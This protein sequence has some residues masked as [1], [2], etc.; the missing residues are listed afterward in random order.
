MVW[1]KKT[2]DTAV[3]EENAEAAAGEDRDK[4]ITEADKQELLE[5]FD[6]ESKTRTFVSP[7]V[8]MAYKIFAIL[9]TLYHLVFASG[10]WM[11]ETLKHRSLHVSM[12]LILAFAMYPATKKASRKIIAWYDYI[13]IALSAAVP[14][15]MWLD[16]F[17]IIN[18]AGK[19]NSM[20][21]IIGTLLT[22]L[23]LEATRRVCGMA[24]PIL[25]VIFI[26]YS[27]MGTKQGLI[28]VNIPGIFLHRG[29]TWQKL[30]SHFFA[31]TEG[32]YGSSVNVASTYIFL[33]IAFGEIMNKCGMGKFFNDIANA[34][35]G[36]SKGGPA[37]VAVVA[38]GL[39]GMING[40]AVAVV[41][42]T[43][44]FTI[45]LMK[46]T[47]Y[48]NEFSGAIVATGS[49][50]GQLMP[51]VMGA[52]A[53][54]MAETLG[55]KYSTLLVSAIIPAVIYYM[56]ILLQ[57]QMRAEKMGMQGT[58]KDQLPKVGEVMKEYG[59]LAIPLVFLI[60]M[61]FFSGKTVIM[62]AFYTILFTIVV[63]QLRPNTRMSLNDIID[64]M[65][66]SA[67]STVSVAIACACVGIIVGVCSIT[68]FAL[69]MASTIIQIGGQSLMFT[70][71]FTMVTCMIL[72]MGLPSIPSY[73]I[74]STIAAPALVTLGI[75]P[76][77]AHMFCFYFAM[78]ANLTPPVALAAFA[79]AGIAGGSPM[80]TGWAS[81]KL[82]LAG[83]I[84]P[85]MFVYNTELLLLDTP[86]AKGIQV[87][88][89]AAIGVFLISVAVE[90]F[91]FRKVNAV[92]RILC[93]A[94]AYLLID[95]GLITDIIGIAIC[96]GIVLLQKTMA[97]K[98][99]TIV[100]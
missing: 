12:I 9:V 7:A 58:P 79:A 70:L 84:L 65:V 94:G 93:F 45:P 1:K 31:N 74:T 38:S 35:A 3:P 25:G 69:N 13:L 98:H 91:L 28:P 37:K 62:A 44:S 18:R 100:T 61:L 34:L 33:F 36:G 56:G 54:I 27:L 95:S 15:Y 24:L 14:L 30:M 92:L 89:T 42:T 19:P 63:A 82:A 39:L 20:D 2:A 64:A 67:K 16:Y 85:Y 49:V 83:F 47:G 73:I 59:H 4:E 71:M 76:I 23:V 72:G 51:P 5:K 11:P 29:Y 41:V 80:K 8:A 81:V 99:G 50:G 86:I 26:L 10:F 6:K 77:A 22:L 46:K 75:P 57:I 52:A 87:A 32:I 53:F 48:D 43:G 60:Y 17:N 90:G 66:A 40:A 78:F 96:V 55:I 68:G 97:K 88:I 21:V